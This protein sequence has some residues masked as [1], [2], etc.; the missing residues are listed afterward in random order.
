MQ[1]KTLI[2]PLDGLL[3]IVLSGSLFA[4]SVTL[5]SVVRFVFRRRGSSW[6]PSATPVLG[7][8]A[9]VQQR[10]A[11]PGRNPWTNRGRE[12]LVVTDTSLTPG[13]PQRTA[14]WMIWFRSQRSLLHGGGRGWGWWRWKESR[15][16]GCRSYSLYDVSI[17]RISSVSVTSSFVH[18]PPLVRS[19]AS[20][21]CFMGNSCT[22]WRGVRGLR[23]RYLGYLHRNVFKYTN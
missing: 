1:T 4:L 13:F 11:I 16:R 8:S 17:M 10:R 18:L 14:A 3:F 6:N 15:G 23:W 21:K 9:S 19:P 2:Q 22:C 7:R 12:E 20:M 5:L